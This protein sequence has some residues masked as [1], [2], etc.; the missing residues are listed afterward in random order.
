MIPNRG[1]QHILS[2][3]IFTEIGPFSIQIKLNTFYSQNKD[4]EGWRG[5][6]WSLSCDLG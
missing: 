4:F 5:T 6:Q 1:Y 2:F 3:G